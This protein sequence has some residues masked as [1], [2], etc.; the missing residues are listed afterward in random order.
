MSEAPLPPAAYAAALASLA[1]VGPARLRRLLAG[2]DPCAAW[3]A[4][5]A[6]QLWPG[7]EEL[8]VD[9][10]PRGDRPQSGGARA[11]SA[12]LR[13]SW[14]RS[15]ASVEVALLWE[16]H[17]Q[18]G[19]EVLLPG[20]DAYPSALIEDHQR[21]EV[22][23]VKGLPLRPR[24]TVAI[25]GTRRCTRYGVEVAGSLATSLASAGVDVIS[26][27]A[28]GIDAAAHA[29]LVG[30]PAEGHAV[31]VVGTGLDQ[32]YP[33]RNAALW[34]A[35]GRV[36]TLVSEAPL[37][38]P[39]APWRFPA[40]NRIIAALAQVVVV[41]ESAVSGGSMHTVR[42]A[43][44][45]NRVVMA[46]PG[47]ITSNASEGTNSLIAD[48][49]APCLG[50]TDV[51]VAL[52]WSAPTPTSHPLALPPLDPELQVAM[53]VLDDGPATYDDLAVA[54]RCDVEGVVRIVGHLVEAGA[55]RDD[56]GL[57]VAA[58]PER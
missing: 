52:G 11:I 26:G 7:H 27:L 8:P 16:R 33:A 55:V 54:L 9:D 34:R 23:F 2:G 46:V 10:V 45:R 35:V 39:G 53:R 21:P 5:C 38:T 28:H 1:E 30:D 50:V 4:V 31:A 49:V 18:L 36:G 32:P 17:L 58:L 22:L 37:G 57:V 20:D 14:E 47:P 24:P 41:V 43:D 29:A 15:A 25:V 42:Q 19:V 56:G 48:G 51:L 44:V 12:D 13:R 6:G 40:R 3:S